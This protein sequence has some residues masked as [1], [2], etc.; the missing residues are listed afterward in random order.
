MKTE[1]S[2]DLLMRL[3][4]KTEEHLTTAVQT[5][6]NLEDENLLRP[7]AHGGWSIAQCLEHLNRYGNFYLPQIKL[8]IEKSQAAHDYFKSGWFGNYFT[9]MMDPSSRKNYK[10][11]K[12]YIPPLE[13]RAHEVVAEFIHQ[14]ETLLN[15]LCRASKADLN[16]RV[17]ISITS[18]V[19]LKLGDV[20]QFLIMHN[21]RHMRQA[22]RNCQ[23]ENQFV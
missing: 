1:K 3:E 8:A 17:P 5:F 6:Q 9:N 16:I 23:R 22:K 13:L 12:E 4:K 11:F 7:A 20:F 14:Q 10:A 18:F 2:I 19:K 21:E 15:Y